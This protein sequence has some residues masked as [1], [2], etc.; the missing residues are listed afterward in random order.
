MTPP[1]NRDRDTAIGHALQHWLNERNMSHVAFAKT[2]HVAAPLVQNWC[3]NG[4]RPNSRVRDALSGA[5]GWNWND[6]DSIA[7]LWH[8]LNLPPPVRKKTASVVHLKKKAPKL[9]FTS[10]EGPMIAAARIQAVLTSKQPLDPANA[11]DR[12]VLLFVSE[13]LASEIARRER[14][15]PKYKTLAGIREIVLTHPNPQAALAMFREHASV[16]KDIL[17][18]IARSLPTGIAVT[19]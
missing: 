13:S 19:A 3:T 9:T 14:E 1:K 16:D 7:A 12:A 6:P 10:L 5:T 8:S 18:A 15:D 11:E 2:I 4:T 17:D